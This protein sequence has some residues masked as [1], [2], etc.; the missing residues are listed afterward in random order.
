VHRI[1]LSAKTVP[2]PPV[3]E[4]HAVSCSAR[5]K[6]RSAEGCWTLTINHELLQL[7]ILTR[8]KMCPRQ[9]DSSTQKCHR[10]S[11]CCV[12]SSLP[13]TLR[14]RS[15]VGPGDVNSCLWWD[16]PLLCWDALAGEGCD[17]KP[18]IG[19]PLVWECEWVCCAGPVSLL[20]NKVAVNTTK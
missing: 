18:H 4:P 17:T 19:I 6:V 13:W 1:A 15:S 12:L 20:W 7:L 2:F 14:Y 10:M 3:W 5:V 11:C 9:N 8:W 16:W